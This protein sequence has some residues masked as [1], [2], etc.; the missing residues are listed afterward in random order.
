MLKIPPPPLFKVG[1]LARSGSGRR[2][3]VVG[4][5]SPGGQEAGGKLPSEFS[6]FSALAQDSAG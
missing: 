4:C 3:V 2:P 1:P 6:L 5:G